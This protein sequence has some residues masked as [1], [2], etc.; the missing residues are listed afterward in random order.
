M[1]GAVVSVLRLVSP[2]PVY[3]DWVVVVVVCWTFQQDASVSQRQVCS[4]NCMYIVTEDADE[5][6]HPNW[7]QCTDTGAN[8]PR[9]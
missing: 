5:T 1:P 2:L 4:D 7:F 6:V 3:F 8:Q 9:H